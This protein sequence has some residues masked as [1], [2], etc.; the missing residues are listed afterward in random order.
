M[1]ES[2][3][4]LKNLHVSC[5]C[6]HDRL[7]IFVARSYL[8]GQRVVD[9]GESLGEDTQVV[10]DLLLLL[11]VLED[12]SVDFL[13][14]LFQ[15]FDTFHQ[16]IVVVLQRSALA[17]H[18]AAVRSGPVGS[19]REI[20]ATRRPAAA[21]GSSVTPTE[22]LPYFTPQY[23]RGPAARPGPGLPRRVPGRVLSC[24]SAWA[25]PSRHGPRLRTAA[26]AYG[27]YSTERSKVTSNLNYSC[28]TLDD[29][30][31]TSDL[32]PQVRAG[33]RCVPNVQSIH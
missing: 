24:H 28:W 9:A 11:L 6:L 5:L 18:R 33:S 4:T 26:P 12:L 29:T 30:D 14:L 19:L 15:I 16:L 10:L 27:D 31:S 17:R 21:P 1:E 8:S 20:R 2:L 23:R 22:R 7:V 3:R 13:S 25:A 32:P